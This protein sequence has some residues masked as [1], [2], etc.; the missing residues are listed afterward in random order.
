LH[1]IFAVT[2]CRKLIELPASQKSIQKTGTGCFNEDVFALHAVPLLIA[3]T[4]NPHTIA[5]ELI[6]HGA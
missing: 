3:E 6:L 2:V 5:E 4:R 1:E